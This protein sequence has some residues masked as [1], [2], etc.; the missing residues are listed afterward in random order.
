LLLLQLHLLL[1]EQLLLLQLLLLLNLCLHFLLL[2]NHVG[3]QNR[4]Q[5]RVEGLNGIMP[6][7]AQHQPENYYLGKK[8]KQIKAKQFKSIQSKEKK[9]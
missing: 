1:H 7:T 9:S 8:A 4:Q 2:P 6:P 5:L 3:H